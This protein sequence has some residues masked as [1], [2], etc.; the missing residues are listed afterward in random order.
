MNAFMVWSQLER[1]RIVA[2]TPDMHN[3]EISKQLGRRWKL[4]TEDQRR[5]YR[6]EAQRLKVLHRREYPD[7]K[8][9][10]RKKCNKPISSCNIDQ[11]QPDPLKGIS[12]KTGQGR[13]I[14]GRI[15]KLRHQ[16]GLNLNPKDHDVMIEAIVKLETR[17]SNYNNDNPLGGVPLSPRT[18]FPSSPSNILPNSPESAVLYDDYKIL[19]NVYAKRDPCIGGKITADE[20]KQH[21]NQIDWHTVPNQII[22]NNIINQEVDDLSSLDDL[23]GIVVKDLVPL[24]TELSLDL[25]VLDATSLDLWSNQDVDNRNLAT[26]P[27][28]TVSQQND[29]SININWPEDLVESFWSKDCNEMKIQNNDCETLLGSSS[30]FSSSWL[31]PVLEASYSLNDL[32][33]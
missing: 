2:Q 28:P 14:G 32:T 11:R 31:R 15:T 9:R 27:T 21:F 1:R 25:Q 6:E 12:D 20:R 26:P 8:Y 19:Q 23:D 16:G 24:S 33:R 30:N 4:L 18:H 17:P 29:P 22:S 3:A 10:P 7:Y 5:P 13:N